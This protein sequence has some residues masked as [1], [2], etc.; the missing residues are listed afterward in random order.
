MATRVRSFSLKIASWMRSAVPIPQTKLAANWPDMVRKFDSRSKQAVS[1]DEEERIS[2]AANLSRVYTNRPVRATA[3]TLWENAG[4]TNREIMAISG[5]R[6]E[7]SLQSYHNM[8]SANQLRKCS[9][10]LSLALGFF[11]CFLFCF[12][13]FFTSTGSDSIF[14]MKH[15]LL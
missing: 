6:N 15:A 12:V 14:L 4:L 2:S 13:F 7:W 9:N 10:V 1:N 8:P 11:F 5:H 3:I